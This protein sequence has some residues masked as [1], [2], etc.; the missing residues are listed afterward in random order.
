MD[1]LF[2]LFRRLL[3]FQ[4]R[5]Y[6]KTIW[7]MFVDIVKLQVENDCRIRTYQE[8]CAEIEKLEWPGQTILRWKGLAKHNGIAE[9]AWVMV[10]GVLDERMLVAAGKGVE[11]Y[12]EH[13]KRGAYRQYLSLVA[14]GEEK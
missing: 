8:F 12:M 5:A 1:E 11:D 14:W 2:A 13:K 9:D 7:R 4:E 10:D 3:Q 6:T